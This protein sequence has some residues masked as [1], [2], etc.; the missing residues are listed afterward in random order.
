MLGQALRDGLPL[1]IVIGA[2]E[3]S[4]ESVHDVIEGVERLGLASSRISGVPLMRALRHL[5]F[6]HPEPGRL[7]RCHPRA[8][9]NR[10]SGQ[11]GSRSK[12]LSRFRR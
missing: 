2:G 11:E 10:G 6:R 9:S 1:G 5:V 8:A 12:S 7:A 4:F 3:G